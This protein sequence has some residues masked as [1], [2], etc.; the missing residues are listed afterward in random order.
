MKYIFLI[1]VFSCSVVL[2]HSSP[3][4]PSPEGNS[5]VDVKIASVEWRALLVA[6]KHL[7]S[8]KDYT[9]EQ[10]NPENYEVW[11]H[12]G[13]DVIEVSFIG[14][15]KNLEDVK[16]GGN[17]DFARSCTYFISTDSF[18]IIRIERSR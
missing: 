6:L 9:P 4:T 1:T 11:I 7:Q 5:S 18:G 14:F 12:S 3:Q 16:K 13:K 17:Y 15:Q 10:R 2:G 8:R